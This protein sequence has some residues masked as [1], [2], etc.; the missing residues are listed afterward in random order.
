MS[1]V[2]CAL[3]VLRLGMQK[4]ERGRSW[5]ELS[6]QSSEDIQRDVLFAMRFPLIVLSVRELS[7]LHKILCLTDEKEGLRLCVSSKK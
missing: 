3:T 2:P 6:V 7:S 5:V 4:A 1:N